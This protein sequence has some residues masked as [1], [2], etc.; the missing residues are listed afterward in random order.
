MGNCQSNSHP[1]QDVLVGHQSALTP[2]KASFVEDRKDVTE[3]TESDSVTLP[4][5]PDTTWS[6]LSPQSNYALSPLSLKV[7]L[8][9]SSLDQ[10]QV[11]YAVVEAGKQQRP[12]QHGRITRSFSGSSPPRPKGRALQHR[13]KKAR[14]M[15]MALSKLDSNR[16]LGSVASMSI[17]SRSSTLGDESLHS[18]QQQLPMVPYRFSMSAESTTHSSDHINDEFEATISRA[19]IWAEVEHSDKVLAVA[20]S[21]TE[22]SLNQQTPPLFLAVGTE[23]GTTTI[24]EVLDDSPISST[25]AVS[26]NNDHSSVSADTNSNRLGDSL[27]IHRQGRVR[28]LDFSPDGKYLAI[29][30]D[31]CAC[32][33]YRMDFAQMMDGSEILRHL[34]LCAVVQRVD[35]V[36]AIQF[37]PDNRYLAIGGFDGSVAIIAVDQIP[38]SGS[39][40]VIAEIPIDGLIFTLDWSPDSRMLAIGG[41]DKCCSVV[42]VDSSW[43][44]F[45]TI[46]RPSSV[47]TVKWHPIGGRYLAIGAAGD[48]AIVDRESFK[49]KHVIDLR[50]QS[51]GKGVNRSVYRVN[52]L[53]WS[54][55]GSYLVLC[56]SEQVCTLVEGKTFA[57]VHEVRCGGNVTSAV[58]GQQSTITGLPRRYLVLGGEDRKAVILKAGL[59]I[60]S[61]AS[62]IGDDL[63]STAS[64]Y[65]SN[66]GEWTLKEN[67]FRDVDDAFEPSPLDNQFDSQAKAN[68]TGVA[69]SR[70]SKSRTSAFFACA[71]DDGIVTIRCTVKWNIITE[72]AFPKP[73]RSLTF[74][75]GSGYLALASEASTLYIVQIPSWSVVAAKDVGAPISSVVF[76]KNNARLAVGSADGILSLLDPHKS[77][78]ATGEIESNTSP[79]LALDWSSKCLAIARRDGSVCIYDSDQVYSNFCVALAELAHTTPVRAVAFGV[80]SRFLAVG[81]DNGL[82]SLYSAKGGWVLC[83]QVKVDCAISSIKWSPTGRFMAFGGDNGLFQVI[84]T[85]FWAEVD[86][87]KTLVSSEI[88]ASISSLA[89]SQD[90]KL[91]AYGGH[92]FGA[93]VVDSSTWDVNF[94][95]QNTREGLADESSIS[96]QEEDIEGIPLD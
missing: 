93:S 8:T 7:P 79:I 5:S 26:N 35:R 15:Q 39:P 57:P 31:D 73:I 38:R 61:G 43:Q 21:R 28:T 45:R 50:A 91:I 89:F 30:G 83:H 55:N 92:A 68:V 90:G 14:Y 23:D 77:W 10:Q 64:S 53:C 63:S 13:L 17:T 3:S 69:F 74:S 62:S 46:K 75:N 6:P 32:G 48:V 94:T 33:V 9:F 80:S 42:D 25:T 60:S 84:D 95:L 51:S 56:N 27:S 12:L 37:S 78:E 4:L 11:S 29:G 54:P 81:G 86:E 71:T 76:S 82:L 88:N 40:D 34:Q 24:Q 49:A 65:F 67:A 41:S 58:W 19:T 47:Q 66:R 22:P 18:R 70:G 1:Q 85:I 20:L 16:S 96:S 36:Y 87:A 52:A 2:I 44:I 72:L 59:E